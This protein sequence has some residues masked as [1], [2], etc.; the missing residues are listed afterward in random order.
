MAS[1]AS[2]PEVAARVSFSSSRVSRER[3]SSSRSRSKRRRPLLGPGLF[4]CDPFGFGAGLRQGGL[5][6]GEGLGLLREGLLPFRKGLAEG[7]AI[8]LQFGEAR[9]RF[10]QFLLHLTLR[11][12]FGRQGGGQ[13]LRHS[14]VVLRRILRHL[15][16]GLPDRDR[17]SRL[18]ELRQ[19]QQA[20]EEKVADDE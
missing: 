16:Y 6:C 15:R 7:G 13:Q 10:L 12:L 17:M 2:C 1:A 11:G 8:L 20:Q 5:S 9:P 19:S 3:A 18:F 4:R 14:G